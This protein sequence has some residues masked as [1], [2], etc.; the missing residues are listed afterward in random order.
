[1]EGG[2]GV[3]QHSSPG[4]AHEAGK[5]HHS[6]EQYCT[7]RNSTTVVT[8]PKGLG[9]TAAPY[10]TMVGRTSYPGSPPSFSSAPPFGQDIHSLEPN[11]L[12]HTFAPGLIWNIRI[13]KY[14]ASPWS[15]TRSSEAVEE[16]RDTGN[17]GDA[18]CRK[19]RAVT[20]AYHELAYLARLHGL[21]TEGSLRVRFKWL[22]L[23]YMQY[24]VQT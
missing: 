7:V 2:C 19:Y 16:E 8:Q 10:C 18:G 11:Q 1:M 23:L 21:R 13:L 9:A 6:T 5:S 14:N 4:Q 24:F 22:L 12:I 3:V 15:A 17:A 20:M